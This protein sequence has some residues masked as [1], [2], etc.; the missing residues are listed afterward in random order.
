MLKRT[1][2]RQRTVFPARSVYPYRSTCL[3]A[4]SLLEEH[5]ITLQRPTDCHLHT[6]NVYA[7]LPQ[8]RKRL[9]RFHR[10]SKSTLFSK[11]SISPPFA[12][13]V[14]LARERDQ[15]LALKQSSRISLFVEQLHLTNPGHFAAAPRKL[16]VK[17]HLV[18]DFATTRT[19]RDGESVCLNRRLH[20]CLDF[21]ASKHERKNSHFLD[22]P[23]NLPIR[24]T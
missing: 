15:R 20:S 12:S 16:A 3:S 8:C 18:L 4:T 6:L 5:S 9:A 22:Q 19:R 17:A 7:Q 10:G 1:P 21:L 2:T 24:V 23:H 13:L 14:N 11:D